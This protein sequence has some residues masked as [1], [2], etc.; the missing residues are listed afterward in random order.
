LPNRI[1][2]EAEQQRLPFEEEDKSS[3]MDK[4]IPDEVRF[5]EFIKTNSFLPGTFTIFTGISKWL[6]KKYFFFCP[7]KEG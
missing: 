4:T 2:D 5:R 6:G 3:M 7:E 1:E